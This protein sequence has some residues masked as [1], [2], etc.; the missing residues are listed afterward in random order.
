[1]QPEKIEHYSAS[2]HIVGFEALNASRQIS[3]PAK[4]EYEIA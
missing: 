2:G 1:L 4:V 3:N